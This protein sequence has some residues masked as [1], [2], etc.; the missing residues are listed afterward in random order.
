MEDMSLEFENHHLRIVVSFC[1][2]TAVDGFLQEMKLNWYYTIGLVKLIF[3]IYHHYNAS[4]RRGLKI[5]ENDSASILF[6]LKSVINMEDELQEVS[7]SS[8]IESSEEVKLL[9]DEQERASH[10]IWVKLLDYIIGRKEFWS[11]LKLV[12]QV[13]VL[14][15]QTLCLVNLEDSNIGYLYQM[16]ERL[17]DGIEKSREQDPF[18]FD[19]SWES[20]T[21]MRSLIIHPIHAAAAFL[22][23][24]YM[25]TE[26]FEINA[27]MK[28]GID[29][30]FENMIDSDEKEAFTTELQKYRM[31]LPELF[32]AQAVTMLKTGHPRIWWD[33]CGKH[34][35][36]VLSKY[37]IRILSQ[38]C[39]TLFCWRFGMRPV[40][41][42]WK[43]DWRS[44]DDYEMGEGWTRKVNTVIMNEN[45][46][47]L[48]LEPIILDKLGED[49]GGFNDWTEQQ[50]ECYFSSLSKGFIDDALVDCMKN[51]SSPFWDNVSENMQPIGFNWDRFRFI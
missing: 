31:K 44:D 16:I 9:D 25:Y 34:T 13:W 26:N 36:P 41:Y 24:A 11:G 8:I 49:L 10:F 47:S 28:V 23:P 40:D 46:R 32:T 27:E 43:E 14:L 12:A 22:D 1:A 48:K 38:P 20:F 4:F 21:H 33:Y 29:Y 35:V 39:S 15:Y 37:A 42:E 30:M 51:D 5:P 50:F 3:C 2:A 7:F 18:F 17:K 45:S 6:M 19:C